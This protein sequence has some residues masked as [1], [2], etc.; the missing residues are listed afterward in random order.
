VATERDAKQSAAFVSLSIAGFVDYN[1][2]ELAL[3]SG[4]TPVLYAL[5]LEGVR[6]G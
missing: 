4:A 6:F 2:L 1:V 5:M 3:E